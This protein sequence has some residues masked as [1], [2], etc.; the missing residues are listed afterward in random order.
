M[1]VATDCKN[2]KPIMDT[3]WINEEVAGMSFCGHACV[4]TFEGSTSDTDAGYHD[5]ALIKESAEAV[6]WVIVRYC[7][8]NRW[9]NFQSPAATAA[10]GTVIT[11][12]A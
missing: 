2:V 6:K 10:A 11:E 9:E 7:M 3:L 1:I 12:F 8:P 4:S 5:E